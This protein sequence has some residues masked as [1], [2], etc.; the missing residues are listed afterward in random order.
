MPG[1]RVSALCRLMRGLRVDAKPQIDTRAL[2]SVRA[3][4]GTRGQK[5][6]AQ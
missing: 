3:A 1:L 5:R 2:V 4:R 6:T